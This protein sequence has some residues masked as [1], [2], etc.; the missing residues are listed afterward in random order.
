MQEV[1]FKWLTIIRI[2]L[3]AKYS[4]NLKWEPVADL[5]GAAA[6]ENR[7]FRFEKKLK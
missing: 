1:F 4:D 2:V 3:T 5:R 6:Q 7:F